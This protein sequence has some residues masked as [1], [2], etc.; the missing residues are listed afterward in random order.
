[1]W[2]AVGLTERYATPAFWGG[3]AFQ[4]AISGVFLLFVVAAVRRRPGALD[5]IFG[6]NYRRNEVRVA[7]VAQLLPL[8]NGVAR[9]YEQVADTPPETVDRP[10]H[11]GLVVLVTALAVALAVWSRNAGESEPPRWPHSA[12]S[13]GVLAFIVFG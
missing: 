6:S 2:V 7:L 5:R 1:V 3:V 13:A 12:A 8:M 9:L 11:L 10:L 4:F